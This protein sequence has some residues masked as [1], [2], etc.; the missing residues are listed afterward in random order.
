MISIFKYQLEK[1]DTFTIKMP[2]D[3]KILTVQ[4]QRG[5]PCIWAMV[6]TTHEQVDRHFVI[7]G[8]G[9]EIQA[10]EKLNYIGTF[11][12]LGGALIWHLFEKLI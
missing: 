7:I 11:Q 2:R 9:H 1:L 12:E 3:A 4:A 6:D 8:T 10:S 5:M